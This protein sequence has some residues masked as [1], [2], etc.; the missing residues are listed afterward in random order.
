M[1][2]NNIP[3]WNLDSI[4]TGLESEEYKNTLADVKNCMENIS[5]LLDTA[6]NYTKEDNE[7]F[8]FAAW[9]EKYLEA[10]NTLSAYFS[11]LMSYGYALYATDTTNTSYINNLN[12]IDELTTTATQLEL[13]FSTLLVAH[14]TSLED[15]FKRFPK[16]EEHRYVLNKTIESKKHQMSPAEE[17]LA[18]EMS[19][20][21]GNAWGQLQEQIISNLADENGKTFN[22]LRN[23]ANSGDEKLRYESWKKEVALLTQNRIAFGAALNNLKGETITLNKK[24]NWNTALDR[25]LSGCRLNNDTLNALISAIE[26]SLPMWRSYLQA[27][28]KLLRLSGKTVSKTAGTAEHPGIAF[29]DMFAPVENP[30]EKAAPSEES[31]F[32]KTWTFPEAKEYILKEFSS[33][34][35]DMG[36]FAKHAFENNWIDA[37]VRP[38][39]VGGAFDTDFA[40]GHESRILSNFTGAFSDIIT[41]SH[42]LGHAYHFSCL[43][44]KDAKFFNYPMTL[45]ESAST[46]AETVVKQDVLKQSNGFDKIKIMDTDLTDACQVFVDILSRFYFERSVFEERANSEL[47]ADDF[48]RLMQNAQEKSYGDGLNNERTEDGTNYT[49]RHDYMWAV[50]GHYY[51]TGLDFYNFPYA[52]GQLFAAGL[53]QRSLSEGPQFAKTYAEILSDTGSMSCEELCKKAGFDI[54]KKDFWAQGLSM[55]TKEI[56]EYVDYVKAL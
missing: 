49:E 45:A 19:R 15:F 32:T 56:Q 10:D 25:S 26:D 12:A 1:E 11:T 22:E 5:A 6:D 8:D 38:G 51:S 42:E 20:T 2:N 50:K 47:N 34:S 7:H 9:L 3:R 46:F 41:L 16:Y 29:Y 18:A 30:N 40:K 33:F 36:N 21:G 39:K 28:A 31:L 24:R 48:C 14:Q 44:G 55:Y 23:D 13:R 27:K 54:T 52:F 17:K 37:E 53:Y 35:E 4:F 43:K